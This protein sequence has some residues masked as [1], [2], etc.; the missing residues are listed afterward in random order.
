MCLPTALHKE[1]TLKALAAGKHVMCEKP[2]ALDYADCVEMAEAADRA[3]KQLMIGQCLRF[4]PCYIY[5]KELVD[6]KK[7]GKARRV[8]MSRLTAAARLLSN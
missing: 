6:S 1:F 4:D 7:Y 5:L 2:M 8:F 3:G